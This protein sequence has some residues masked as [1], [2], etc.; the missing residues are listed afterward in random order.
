MTDIPFTPAPH[1]EKRII[2]SLERSLSWLA[3][4]LKLTK[5][6]STMDEGSHPN[7]FVHMAGGIN[8]VARDDFATGLLEPLEGPE[9]RTLNPLGLHTLDD[10]I[11]G[12]V[13]DLVPLQT[14]LN[15]ALDEETTLIPLIHTS[16]SPLP[17]S[18][19]RLA[20]SSTSPHQI[21]HLIEN[22][23]DLFD[24]HFAQKAA[25]WGVA[26][27]FKFPAPDGP[28]KSSIGHN[29]YD[30]SHADEFIP[31]SSN[32]MGAAEQTTEKNKPSCSCIAC[33][34]KFSS[35]PIIHS[36][37]DSIS[38]TTD[39]SESHAPPVTRAY[40]H[41][42]LHTHEMAAHAM[43]ASH[44]ITILSQFLADIR[45]HLTQSPDTFSS[46]IR[47]FESVYAS[48]LGD[49][50]VLAKAKKQ[51]EEVDLARGKGRM[52]REKAAKDAD[53]QVIVDQEAAGMVNKLQRLDVAANV[54]D[55]ILGS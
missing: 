43:L 32:F 21:L 23:I 49:E 14:S 34:P 8:D 48:P 10:G 20:T 22:G 38:W 54:A 46:E 15:S 19:P 6:P 33:S 41:H 44:N 7:V 47:R 35:N 4:L 26:L 37:I 52:A 45:H 13:F 11:S 29:L 9:A 5:P 31:L 30:E 24:A 25:D 12:Y 1:S 3:T 51:W 55:E 27:D 50:G 28:P 42:L 36:S 17:P 40:I 16:L 2:K 39:S 18:K 53:A